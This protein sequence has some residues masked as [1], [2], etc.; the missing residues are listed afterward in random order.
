MSGCFISTGKLTNRGKKELVLGNLEYTKIKNIVIHAVPLSYNLA[1][2]AL[3][4]EGKKMS[5][6]LNPALTFTL[7]HIAIQL[8]MENDD[9][10]IIEY[11]QYLSEDSEIKP[12]FL[13][14]SCSKSSQN[15]KTE[16]NENLYYYINKD[17]ARIT[18]INK[19]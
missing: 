5:M 3:R 13:S 11:G 19:E 17:G 12:G 4:T 8:N 18:K 1:T 15:P 10:L 14:S 16:V 9:I 7:R 6:L 2:S